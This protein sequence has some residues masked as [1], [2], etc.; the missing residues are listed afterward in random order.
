MSYQ[1]CA[2]LYPVCNQRLSRAFPDGRVGNSWSFFPAAVS[3]RYIFAHNIYHVFFLLFLKANVP[4]KVQSLLRDILVYTTTTFCKAV[5]IHVF[6]SLYSRAPFAP[7]GMRNGKH[8]LKKYHY[9]KRF[10]FFV[11][12]FRKDSIWSLSISTSKLVVELS[13]LIF[14]CISF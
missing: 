6:S 4:N 8:E 2:R 13:K 1:R 3:T 12:V 10:L 14:G 5:R 7:T 9:D 11:L